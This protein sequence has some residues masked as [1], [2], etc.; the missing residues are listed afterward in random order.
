MPKMMAASSLLALCTRTP[1]RVPKARM[2]EV[3]PMERTWKAT[4]N[5]V[6][7]VTSASTTS[8]ADEI[9]R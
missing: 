7:C 8:A 5:P 9:V 1:V 6:A 4:P 3:S 2:A